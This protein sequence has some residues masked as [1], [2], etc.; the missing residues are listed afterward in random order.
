[1]IVGIADFNRTYGFRYT[2]VFGNRPVDYFYTVVS[3][4]TLCICSWSSFECDSVGSGER[5]RKVN[6]TKRYFANS[7][8]ETL[9][10]GEEFVGFREFH[11]HQKLSLNPLKPSGYYMYH[12]N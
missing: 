8:K 11:H 12:W 7:V 4:E 2:T 3:T 5:E 1:L 9:E 10:F 6:L